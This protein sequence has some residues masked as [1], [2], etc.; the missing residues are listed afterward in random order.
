LDPAKRD[1]QGLGAWMPRVNVQILTTVIHYVFQGLKIEPDPGGMGPTGGILRRRSA[2]RNSIGQAFHRAGAGIEQ[3][4]AFCKELVCAGVA[5]L[6]ELQPSKLN[7]ASSNL[8]SRSKLN[9][10]SLK[11]F[12][13]V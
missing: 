2:R 9:M 6:V 1:P 4:G 10:H 5:Q 7:V 8:V 11:G 3:K 13:V 12:Q